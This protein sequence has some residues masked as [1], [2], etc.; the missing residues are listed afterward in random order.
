MKFTVDS[1]KLKEALE[2]LQVKGKAL[3]NS[4]FSSTNI[5]SYV[6]MHLNG[7]SLN[8]WNG[9]PTFVVNI[10]LEVEGDTDGTV[11]A[12]SNMVLPY[13]KTI[14]ENTCFSVEDF[15]SIASGRK[16]ASIPI[17][18]NHPNM[19]AITR[20]SGMVT[21]VSYQPQPVM[22]FNFGKSKYEG[23]FTLTNKQFTSCIKTCELVKSGVY[24]LDF[25]NGVSKFSTRQSV[26][27]KYEE[28]LTPVFALGEPATIEFSGPL[29]SFFKKEQLLNFYVKDEF[30][31]LIVAEDRLLIR[32]PYVNG[33]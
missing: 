15:I 30:P 17:V 19:D 18:V 6:Y 4:G 28:T 25:N 13:L 7:N 11:I 22:L 14:G 3:G 12:D 27:N 26:Q 21:H 8:L 2:S 32:A 16:G 9:N 20:L 24:K 5:G 33:A 1:A 31:L 29:H 23:A 10:N